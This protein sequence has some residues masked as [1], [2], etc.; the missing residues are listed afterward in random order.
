MYFRRQDR[1]NTG[2]ATVVEDMDE[3]DKILGELAFKKITSGLDNAEV[4]HIDRI[5]ETFKR[6]ATRHEFAASSFHIYL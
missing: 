1:R 4:S 2:Q 5:L 6:R 3:F